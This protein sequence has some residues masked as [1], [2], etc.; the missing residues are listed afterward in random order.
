M[1]TEQS[2]ERS[3]VENLAATTCELYKYSPETETWQLWERSL[4][5]F[6]VKVQVNVPQQLPS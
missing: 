2:K 1:N 6:C 4:E 5:A 3:G